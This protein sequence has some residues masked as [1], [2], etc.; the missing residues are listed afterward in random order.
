MN[1]ETMILWKN[2]DENY[3]EEG[4][5]IIIVIFVMSLKS[6]TI[7]QVVCFRLVNNAR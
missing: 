7:E 2:W 5:V 6:V 3:I 1:V 4:G